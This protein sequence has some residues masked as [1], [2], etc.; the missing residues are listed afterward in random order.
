MVTTC[1]CMALI[2]IHDSE[3]RWTSTVDIANEIHN[4]IMIFMIC[5]TRVA[6]HK[7][8]DECLGLDSSLA[9]LLLLNSWPHIVAFCCIFDSWLVLKIFWIT[10][11]EVSDEVCLYNVLEG[12]EKILFACLVGASYNFV[13]FNLI[14]CHQLL[15]IWALYQCCVYNNFLVVWLCTEIGWI[16]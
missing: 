1:P 16:N 6:T 14:C 12:W 4:P 13:I 8:L 2:E 7:G 15:Y 11:I 3:T 9:C 5:L 10:R